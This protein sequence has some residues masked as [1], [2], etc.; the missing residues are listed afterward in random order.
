MSH[1]IEDPRRR[2]LDYRSVAP[3]IIGKML[4]AGVEAESMDERFSMEIIWHDSG[5]AEACEAE[6]GTSAEPSCW[7]FVGYASGYTSFC[8]GKSV[9]FIERQCRA[10]GDPTCFVVG[11]DIDSWDDEIRPSL[12]FFHAGDI[13]ATLYRRLQRDNDT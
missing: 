7:I 11:K 4:A 10:K 12:E 8:L 5:E 1:T 3:W 9:Y 2:S 6:L 13:Q